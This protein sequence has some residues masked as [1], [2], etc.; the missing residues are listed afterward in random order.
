LFGRHGCSLSEEMDEWDMKSDGAD[1]EIELVHSLTQSATPHLL[2]CFSLPAA[3][4]S[5]F[6]D[7]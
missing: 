4:V 3:L 5:L 6:I 1:V 2:I 7:I